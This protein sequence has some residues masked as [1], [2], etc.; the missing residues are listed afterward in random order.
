MR[1]WSIADRYHSLW[2]RAKARNDSFKTLHGGQFTLFFTNSITVSLE[3]YPLS[4]LLSNSSSIFLITTFT[5]VTSVSSRLFNQKKF[6]RTTIRITNHYM[7]RKS[8]IKT[9]AGYSKELKSSTVLCACVHLIPWN[10]VIDWRAH[11]LTHVTMTSSPFFYFT[12]K[13]CWLCFARQLGLLW[14]QRNIEKK[15]RIE[16]FYTSLSLG[17]T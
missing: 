9:V 11:S 10:S 16:N 3:T 15:S 13:F 8:A 17:Y 7:S 6:I 2:R 5:P 1:Q 14:E 4:S 12:R